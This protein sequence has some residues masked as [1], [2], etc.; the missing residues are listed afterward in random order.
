MYGCGHRGGKT[1]ALQRPVTTRYATASF[2]EPGDPAASGGFNSGD[3]IKH[4]RPSRARDGRAAYA[5]RAPS[6][7]LKSATGQTKFR[8]SAT[9]IRVAAHPPRAAPDFG[10][11]NPLVEPPSRAGFRVR[12]AMTRRHALQA[13]SRPW[14]RPRSGGIL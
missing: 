11:E 13:V 9:I 6:S 10:E 2:G 14:A 8:L 1:R 12:R 7:S 5:G 4:H 3:I